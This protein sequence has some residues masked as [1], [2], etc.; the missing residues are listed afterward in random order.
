MSD[1]LNGAAVPWDLVSGPV[2]PIGTSAR[3]REACRPTGRLSVVVRAEAES[4]ATV[5]E[6]VSQRIDEHVLAVACDGDADS[7]LRQR[8]TVAAA[9]VIAGRRR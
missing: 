6:E 5:A 3:T 7:T 8:M 2:E 4:I 9:R 1:L